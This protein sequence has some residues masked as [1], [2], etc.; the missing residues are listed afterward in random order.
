MPN[1]PI[2]PEG[3][4]PLMLT[5]DGQ[6]PEEIAYGPPIMMARLERWVSTYFANLKSDTDKAMRELHREPPIIVNV[7]AA[8]KVDSLTAADALREAREFAK[9]QFPGQPTMDWDPFVGWEFQWADIKIE[10]YSAPNQSAWVRQSSNGVRVIH[11]PTGMVAEEHAHLNV[12]VNK[13][14]AL[15]RMND[16]VRVRNA[17]KD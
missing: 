14:R 5:F 15:N 8:L 6:H 12:F 4:I 9:C 16:M 13:Q 11:T 7:D 2:L 1:K 17:K 3:W 10:T